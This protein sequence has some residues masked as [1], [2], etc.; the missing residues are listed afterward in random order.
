MSATGSTVCGTI[1]NVMSTSAQ[2]LSPPQLR[3]LRNL[4]DGRLPTYGDP[5]VRNRSRGGHRSQQ[6]HQSLAALARRGLV[7]K[8]LGSWK[9][10]ADGYAMTAG[11]R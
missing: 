9:L 5:L 2:R 11:T 4:L 7:D 6:T 1:T 8:V 10:T 3:V